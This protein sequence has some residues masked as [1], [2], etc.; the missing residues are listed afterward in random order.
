LRAR[1]ADLERKVQ[2][3]AD[4]VLDEEDESL[5]PELRAR[6]LARKQERDAARDELAALQ[7]RPATS[8]DQQAGVDA[9]VPMMT[10]LVECVR[11]DDAAELQTVLRE[12]VSYV[13]VWF[14]PEQCGRRTFNRYARGLVYLREDLRLKYIR[15][16]LPGPRES[17]QPGIYDQ[18]K[19]FLS[20]VL[21]PPA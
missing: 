18:A 6:L 9:A 3:A 5:L 2:Q 20:A 16:Q 11:A 8:A 21:A 12:W 7:A 17:S 14:R 4:R 15:V 10:R 19:A 13:E 1:L